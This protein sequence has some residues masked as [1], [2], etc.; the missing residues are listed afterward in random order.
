MAFRIVLRTLYLD[1]L[2]ADWDVVQAGAELHSPPHD[3]HAATRDVVWPV[4]D[5]T[6]CTTEVFI[7]SNT[8]NFALV[9]RIIAKPEGR[10]NGSTCESVKKEREG[11]P[12][13]SRG[14]LYAIQSLPSTGCSLNATSL[15]LQMQAPI[16]RDAP[17]RLISGRLLAVCE[18]I[19]NW[20]G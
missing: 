5:H 4:S 18:M 7:D 16:V 14:D 12:S 20:S 6:T 19:E 11:S 15:S 8:V 3:G 10:G 9:S 17:F 13:E 2:A 1:H